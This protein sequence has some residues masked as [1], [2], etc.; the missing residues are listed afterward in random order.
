MVRVPGTCPSCPSAQVIT[1]GQTETGTP[2]DR[3]QQTTCAHRSFGLE[4]ADHGGV[5]QV[6]VQFIERALNSRGIRETARVLTLSSTTVLHE[7]NT[8]SRHGAVSTI[9]CSRC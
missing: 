6:K 3:C 9:I 8:K 1:G 4:P 7:L 5:P 2:R